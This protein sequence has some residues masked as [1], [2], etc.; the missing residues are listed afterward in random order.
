L[1]T[2]AQPAVVRRSR[3]WEGLPYWL[4]LPTLAYLV[5]FFAWPMVQAFDLAFRQNGVWTL[6][7]FSRM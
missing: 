4:V 6:D 3:R 1:A 2:V 5:L 7:A